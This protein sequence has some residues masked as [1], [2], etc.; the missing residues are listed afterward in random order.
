NRSHS[1][2]RTSPSRGRKAQSERNF[3]FLSRFFI[4]GG[5]AVT[6]HR[7]PRLLLLNFFLGI[8]CLEGSFAFGGD[9]N[10]DFRKQLQKNLEVRLGLREATA[11]KGIKVSQQPVFIVQ[12]P[13]LVGIVSGTASLGDEIAFALQGA[14]NV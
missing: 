14:T 2:S 4:V 3:W 11:D 13:G 6:G 9:N 1:S 10:K 8:T 7:K 5:F 12:K